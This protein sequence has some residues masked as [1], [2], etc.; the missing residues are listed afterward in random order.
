MSWEKRAS[1]S[2]IPSISTKPTVPSKLLYIPGIETKKI[3][4][5]EIIINSI[6]EEK[7]DGKY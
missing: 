1:I 7:Q 5:K 6:T 4:F 3:K 2:D